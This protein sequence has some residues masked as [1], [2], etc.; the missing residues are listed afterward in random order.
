GIVPGRRHLGTRFTPPPR[1]KNNQADKLFPHRT[2]TSPASKL[3]LFGLAGAPQGSAQVEKM[4]AFQAWGDPYSTR[5]QPAESRV[6]PL[7]ASALDQSK[8]KGSTWFQARGL[9]R[10][11]TFKALDRVHGQGSDDQSKA[12]QDERRGLRRSVH[13]RKA[14]EGFLQPRWI[15]KRICDGQ[16]CRSGTE[17]QADPPERQTNRR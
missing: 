11:S 15:A 6:A 16:R 7:G 12:G 13:S 3:G 9:G 5:P 17:S 2:P 10:G 4:Q 14:H 1:R 8:T